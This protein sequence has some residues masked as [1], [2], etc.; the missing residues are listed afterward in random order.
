MLVSQIFKPKSF[1]FTTQSQLK[2]Y[3]NAK[4]EHLWIVLI[5]IE[6]CPKINMKNLETPL[7]DPDYHLSILS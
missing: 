7:L 4:N 3:P 2:I 6:K 5:V 1:E